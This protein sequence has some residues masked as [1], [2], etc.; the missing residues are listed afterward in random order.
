MMI[1]KKELENFENLLNIMDQLREGCTW[2]KKQT[3][4]S[5]RYLTIEET[6]EL[7][8]A[9]LDNDAQEICKELGDIMLHIVFYAKIGKEKGLFDMSDVLANINKKLIQRHPHIFGNV[10]VANEK[11]VKDNWERI[12]LEKEG[13]KSVLEGVP[14]SMPAIVK[15]YRMQEKAS[16]VGF[17]WENAE[18]VWDKVKEEIDEF[19]EVV[20]NPKEHAHAEEEFGDLMF[21]LIN[22]ARWKN[23]NPEDALEKTNKKFIHRFQ[24][25]E[26]QA[27]KL[28]KNLPD[29]NLNEM[30]ALWQEAKTR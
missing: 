20:D 12:K 28:G 11:E 10:K 6:F 29:M 23:I 26:E 22:Y 19:L 18:Q 4:E 2:D 17:D 7:S 9:I 27:K 25:I 1:M 5:L 14:K 21:S 24:H 16:G 8:D 15:A 3:W 13:K 30:D